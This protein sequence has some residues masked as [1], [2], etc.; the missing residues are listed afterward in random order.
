MN[1]VTRII[2]EAADHLV[3]GGWLAVEMDPD[4]TLNAM[5]LKEQSGRY[6]TPERIKDYSR[7]Y[8]VVM[9]QKR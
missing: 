6:A 3:P 8:R 5:K 9:A 1:L 7:R 2:K 4:Q